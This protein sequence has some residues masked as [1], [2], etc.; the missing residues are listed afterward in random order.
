[1][2]ITIKFEF[3]LHI[4][5]TESRKDVRKE[6][7]SSIADYL[8]S[9]EK[10][11]QRQ[12]L[13][14]RSSTIGNYRTALCSLRQ[15]IKEVCPSGAVIGEELMEGYEQWLRNRRLTLNT[16]SCYMRALRSLMVKTV[17]EEAKTFF[18]K[19]FTGSEKT[20]K[21]AIAPGDISK[22]QD[23]TLKPGSQ[24]SLA[25]DLFLFSFYALGMPFV[26]M[27]L[28]RKQQV[29]ESEIIYSRQKTGQ[30]ICVPLE[31]CLRTIIRRY[32]TPDSDYVFPILQAAEGDKHYKTY[33]NALRRY[34]RSLKRLAQMA[35][36][37][38]NL[39]SYTARHSW[40]SSAFRE[41]V[42][43]PAISK[44]LGHS[45]PQNTLTYIR[46]INDNSL[47]KASRSVIKSVVR[48]C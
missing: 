10:E 23:I 28:L 27:A 6:N 7:K 47:Q 9:A 15:Y 29:G 33:Q 13:L 45:N 18:L 21:R 1:M 46:Q 4:S 5:R 37:P 2:S 44:A 39:T 41:N 14:K 34:N 24:L 35:H 32:Q 42:G 38:H 31:P 12:H 16:I 20:Q 26:D 25:R 19:T 48:R 30:R 36:I 40:A 3:H 8:D 43:L 11:V 22:I 17:G